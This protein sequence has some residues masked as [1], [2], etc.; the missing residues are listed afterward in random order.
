[1]NRKAKGNRIQR[2][3]IKHLEN[4]NWVVAKAEIQTKFSKARDLFG[5][6][7]L[8]CIKPGVVLFVQ[9]TCNKPHT[10][11][12]YLE[13]VNKYGNGSIWIEQ[14]VWVDFIGW[15]QFKYYPNNIKKVVKHG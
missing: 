7:D 13:F 12:Q 10:H 5:L 15:K 4:D 1:M 3:L 2:K 14:W 9:V 6:F 11:K 8:V